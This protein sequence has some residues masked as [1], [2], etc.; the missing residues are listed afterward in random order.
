MMKLVYLGAF[1]LVGV[2]GRYFMSVAVTKLLPGNFPFATFFINILGAFLIG[3]IYVLGFEKAN[4]S[5][6]MRI[7]M[8]AGLLGGFTTFSAYSLE[9]VILI[10]QAR[11]FLSLFY[12]V[13]S[14]VI[15]VLAAMGG[16][17][18]ARFL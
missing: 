18:L 9:A 16:M 12:L 11:P 3:I 17:M 4:I 2:F 8:M 14:S 7:G 10:E 1:G 5:E 6:N 15:G 13:A